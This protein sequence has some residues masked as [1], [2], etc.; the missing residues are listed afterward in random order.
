M[1]RYRGNCIQELGKISRQREFETTTICLVRM[2]HFLAVSCRS[3]AVIPP[4][5]PSTIH[6]LR[7]RL[8]CDAQLGT[9]LVVQVIERH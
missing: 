6:W 4:P 5:G 7:I 8:F 9:G 2:P 1:F 3:G